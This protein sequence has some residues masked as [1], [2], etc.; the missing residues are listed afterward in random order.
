MQQDRLVSGTEILYLSLFVISS[1]YQENYYFDFSLL[2]RIFPNLWL[3]IK[4]LVYLM[5]FII[6]L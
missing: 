5:Q 4:I 1:D 3:A 2:H 6:L